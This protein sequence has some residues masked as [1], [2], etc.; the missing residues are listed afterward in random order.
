MP[1]YEYRCDNTSC[2]SAGERFERLQRL[3]DEAEVPCPTCAIAATRVISAPSVTMGHGHVLKEKHFSERGF[4]QY[5]RLG[6]GVYEKT[7]GTGPKIISDP[8]D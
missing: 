2:A 3:G 8:G 7:A 4:T 6:K 5:K 1:I